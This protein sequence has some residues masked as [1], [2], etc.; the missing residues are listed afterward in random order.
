MSNG[1]L[2]PL[3]LL[4]HVTCAG[5]GWLIRIVSKLHL[6][7]VLGWTMVQRSAEPE[8]EGSQGKE[9]GT[10]SVRVKMNNSH[11][12]CIESRSITS[13]FPNPCLGEETKRK[14]TFA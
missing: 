13:L 14:V 3:A 12:I 9:E 5:L 7:I 1:G 10:R 6:Q 11:E 8:H 2:A 4:F